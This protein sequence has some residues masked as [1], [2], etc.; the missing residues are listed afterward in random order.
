MGLNF[1]SMTINHVFKSVSSRNEKKNNGIFK[2]S[3]T[4]DRHTFECKTNG[5]SAEVWAPCT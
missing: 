3:T 2:S 1:C 4:I 5:R